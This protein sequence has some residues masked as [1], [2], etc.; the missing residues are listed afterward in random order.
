[1]W[2]IPAPAGN[3]H[4]VSPNKEVITVHPRACGEQAGDF[5][6]ADHGDGSSPRLRGTGS[7]S[8]IPG[9]PARFIPAPAGNRGLDL[10]PYPRDTVHPRAC[11]E[12][13]SA[14]IPEN[15]AAG[16]SPRLRGTGDR[17]GIAG[18]V[19][20]FI[21]APAGNSQFFRGSR[22]AN[23]VHPRAC[24][25]QHLHQPFMQ[26]PIGSSPRLRGTGATDLSSTAGRRFIPAPAGNRGRS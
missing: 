11:G 7:H 26:F 23:P 13:D 21:P 22:R 14:L 17:A 19:R 12:Q 25:E 16:S 24:G 9:R 1:M 6:V 4:C 3:S 8:R 5:Q 10:G 2:F 15:P 20:R 18:A